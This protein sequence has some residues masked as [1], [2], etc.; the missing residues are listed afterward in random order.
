MSS[1]REIVQQ[2]LTTGFLTIAEEE[3]LRRLLKT[4]YDWE[5]LDAFTLLQRSVIDGEVKQES[6]QLRASSFHPHVSNYHKKPFTF[7]QEFYEY[8]NAN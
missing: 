4:K 1:I 2:S 3:Q 6:R 7:C 5:D 8:L